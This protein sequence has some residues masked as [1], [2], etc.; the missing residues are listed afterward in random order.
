[1][2]QISPPVC[3]SPSIPLFILTVLDS[4][5]WNIHFY[6]KHLHKEELTFDQLN[7]WC[8]DMK[9]ASEGPGRGWHRKGLMPGPVSQPQRSGAFEEITSSLIPQQESAAYLMFDTHTWGCGIQSDRDNRSTDPCGLQGRL[10]GWRCW[11]NNY[12]TRR[13][14]TSQKYK[15]TRIWEE[16]RRWPH[17]MSMLK[18]QVI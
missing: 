10:L 3:S 4:W 6:I 15:D 17:D 1:M 5:R 9:F 18:M 11:K 12:I 8:C 14:V 2:H 7:V 16:E 13:K